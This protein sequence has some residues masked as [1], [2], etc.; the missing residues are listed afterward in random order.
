MKANKAMDEGLC[1]IR[2][3]IESSLKCSKGEDV[4]CTL[5]VEE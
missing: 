5:L 3:V 2:Q 4:D 1:I